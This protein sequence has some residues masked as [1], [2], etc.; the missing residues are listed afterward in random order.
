MFVCFGVCFFV[1]FAQVFYLTHECIIYVF[2]LNCYFFVS[3]L[4]INYLNCLQF[5]VFFWNIETICIE[6]WRAQMNTTWSKFEKKKNIVNIWFFKQWNQKLDRH[7][8]FG[9]LHSKWSWIWWES[10]I[11]GPPNNWFQMK[12]INPINYMLIF[13]SI[14]T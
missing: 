2:T 13:A 5:G 12:H 11:N 6:W 1:K 10:P 3:F 7:L 9:Q 4:F 14:V 8:Y